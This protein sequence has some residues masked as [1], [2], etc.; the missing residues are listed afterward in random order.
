MSGH[1]L[2]ID[3][4][5]TSSRAIVFD[6]QQKI[7]GLGKMEFTQHFP[8][9]GWV[10]HIPDE[11][12]AT[13]LWS[14]KTAIRKAGIAAGDIAA[15]GITNQRETTIVWDRATGKPIYNAIVWQDRR[16]AGIC[17]R[18]TR[19]GREKLFR[20]KTG[21][22]LDPYFSGT[23][24]KWI[25]D[26]V[27]GARRR[28]EKGELCF[29][30]VDSYL[31]WRLT[32]GKVHATDVTN[33]CRTLL[34]NIETESWDEEL[35]EQ[36]GV[37]L[38]MLPE[39]KD[40]ADDFGTTE[41]SIL[42][43]PVPIRGVAG[44]Q[45]AAT[46]GQ[47]CFVPGMMKSTYGTGCFALLNTGTDLVRSKN[48]LL[49]TIAYRLD[50]KTTYALEGAIFMAG[51]SVQWLRDMLRLFKDAG[52]T[53]SLAQSADPTQDV[54]LVPAFVG[55][56]APW[57]DAEA[58]GAIFGLTRNSGAAELARAAL[59]AVVYQTHDLLTAMRK[60]WKGAQDTVLRVDG[61]MVASD[62]TMQFLADILDAPVDRPTILETTAL[63]AAW[64]AGWKAGVWPDQ[65][66]FAE[67][68]ALDR[69]FHPEMDPALRK[70]KLK[71]WKD[72]VQRTLT[73]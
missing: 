39:I 5:T 7:V 34:F 11:I 1:V 63:G 36:L 73:K 12:W 58:R 21:L 71:G 20:R 66:G 2:A 8:A 16:T 47:A 18:L 57:W 25:L 38:A 4:G 13:C 70:R 37:P 64:L 35:C 9:S 28:A 59:E 49:T 3:Q 15:I 31:I 32:G 24:I 60:D 6:G 40:C 69:Q 33:A 44:D 43:V 61:G 10:E 55:L 30:T 45:Q 48:R 17:E 29:G 14:I 68:W 26:K 65:Q 50:G 51:A 67:S 19:D 72:A 46:I 23:K 42:G 62:W 53:G 22:V 56:G 27:K 54:Y 41:S 52:E